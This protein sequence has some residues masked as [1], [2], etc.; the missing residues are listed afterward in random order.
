MNDN[1]P[2][3]DAVVDAAQAA[4]Q[5]TVADFHPSSPVPHPLEAVSLRVSVED[6]GI[7]IEAEKIQHVFGRFNQADTST[8][9]RYGGTGLGLAISEQLVELM[10]G[11]IGANSVPGEGSTFWFT[12][13]LPRQ[14]DEP[15]ISLPDADLTGL[16]VLIVDDNEVNRRVLHEQITNWKMRNGSYASAPEALAA[17][18]EAHA[19]GD[20]FAIAILDHQMPDMDGEMLGHAIKADPA[21]RETV[22][23]MLT[24]LGRKGDATRLKQAGFAAYLLKPARQSELLGA[25]TYV[26]ATRNAGRPTELV[27][28]HS[29]AETQPARMD[30]AAGTATRWAGTR[31]LVAE[32]NIVNQKVATMILQSFGCHVEVAAN[33][34]EAIQMIEALPYD[35]VFMDCEMPEMDGYE[36]TAEIRLRPD[37]KRGI[38]I[39]AV[40]AKAT[41]G[42][43][44][45]CL[46][47]GMDD[48]ISKP[49][50]AE[51]FQAALERWAAPRDEGRGMRAENGAMKAQVTEEDATAH[52]ASLIPHPLDHEVVAQLRSLAEATDASLL[53]QIFDAFLSDGRARMTTL[54]EAADSGDAARLYH[55]AHA[56]KGASAN[57]GARHMAEICEQLQALGESGSVAGAGD[58]IEEL[59]GEFGRVQGEIKEQLQGPS[60]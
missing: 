28:R 41:R 25:L 8:T 15:V 33:G 47:A 55:A 4:R 20:P 42:D 48:Y 31:A 29:I 18:R 16:R 39:I 56:L 2:R 11:E 17:L 1:L 24:S 38:P 44:E 60:S 12:L 59:D 58:L 10:D 32:D 27:T 19:S 22:L 53:A 49:V 51:D 54:R 7:G 34:K 45:R 6:T 40:T 3:M 9:R 52:P 57:I 46:A 13:R 36:A 43:R 50:K 37:G 26:W 23:V 30:R 14:S 21:L 5:R 35:I